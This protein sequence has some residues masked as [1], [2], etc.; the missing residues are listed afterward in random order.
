M[1]VSGVGLPGFPILEMVVG[2]QALAVTNPNLS[3]Y[4]GSSSSRDLEQRIQATHKNTAII[5]LLHPEPFGL[6]V[7]MHEGA[8]AVYPDPGTRLLSTYFGEATEWVGQD[9][10]EDQTAASAIRLEAG[11]TVLQVMGESIRLY[12][13]PRKSAIVKAGTVLEVTSEG[14]LRREQEGVVVALLREV[15]EERKR[16]TRDARETIERA[17]RAASAEEVRSHNEAM[18]NGEFDKIVGSLRE[19]PDP[20]SPFN[21]HDVLVYFHPGTGKIIHCFGTKLNLDHWDELLTNFPYAVFSVN[22]ATRAIH[23]LDIS[24]N[25]SKSVRD[26]VSNL[27]LLYKRNQ[28]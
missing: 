16:L 23:L 14:H 28:N 4:V 6:T 18:M 22:A 24:G 12:I 1:N 19:H 9:P 11:S 13:S 25:P 7:R 15:R 2:S 8:W 21:L 5:R 17:R 26:I 10:T 3:V 27:P 20:K